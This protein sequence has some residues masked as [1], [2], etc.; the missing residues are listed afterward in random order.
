MWG[1][2]L[3]NPTA[4]GSSRGSPLSHPEFK[5]VPDL[6]GFNS[7]FVRER[8]TPTT[9]T[10]DE[11]KLKELKKRT[12]FPCTSFEVLS[13]HVWRSWARALNLPSNQIIKLVFSVNIRKRIESSLPSGYYGNAFVLGCV[14]TCVRDLTVKGLG[15]TV[16]LVRRAKE[17]VGDEY[18]KEVVELVSSSP[19]SVDSTGVLIMTQ[20][21]RLGLE[22][23]DFGMGRPVQVGPVCCDK[24]CILLPVCNAANSVKVNLAVPSSVVDLYL[25]FLRNICA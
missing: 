22:S 18:V 23:V 6:C 10:F 20:W 7:R 2:H 17:R 13:A 19:A 14:Q 4:F 25:Y 1:R 3:L 16:E 15:Y 9:V 12:K 8:L 11:N 5:S 24:Y 21:S